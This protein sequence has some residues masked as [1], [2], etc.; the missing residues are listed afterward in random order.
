MTNAEEMLYDRNI[1]KAEDKI[2]HT[3]SDIKRNYGERDAEYLRECIDSLKNNLI[4]K[5]NNGNLVL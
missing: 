5:Y 1:R 2:E 3:L 4:M